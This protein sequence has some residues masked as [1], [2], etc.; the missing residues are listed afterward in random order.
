M[1]AS[2]RVPPQGWVSAGAG[3]GCGGEPQAPSSF[4]PRSLG[5]VRSAVEEAP[6][7]ASL[8]GGAS[9]LSTLDSASSGPHFG[10]SGVA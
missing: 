2:S 3:A 5:F 7:S 1:T 9:P 8:P 6:L 10:F 4:L